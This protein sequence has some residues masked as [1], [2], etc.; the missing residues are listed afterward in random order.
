MI[1]A[2]DFKKQIAKPFGQEMRR[3]GFK[4]TGFNYYQ[5]TSDFLFAIYIESARWGG[6]R[7]S[8]GLAVHPKQINKDSNGEID[9]KKI[10]NYDYE[11]K[12][13][14]DVDTHKASWKYSNDEFKNLVTL[15]KIINYIK[16]R[17]FPVIEQFKSNPNILETFEVSEMKDFYENWSKKTGVFLITTELRFAWAMA[18]L[19]E[20]K[21]IS[22][23]NL[24]RNYKKV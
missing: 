12:M 16:E 10:K 18:L 13:S 22:N 1:T 24:R 19:F 9:L 6:S 21:N 14:L 11:F 17:I 2:A 20:D 7:C 23:E 5:E 3:H 15:S 4:G 8:V